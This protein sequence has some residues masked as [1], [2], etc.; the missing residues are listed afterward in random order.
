MSVILYNL[1]LETYAYF[2]NRC[3][4][5]T[6]IDMAMRLHPPWLR[7]NNPTDDSFRLRMLASGRPIILVGRDPVSWLASGYRYTA[8]RDMGQTIFYRSWESH[9]AAAV[10]RNAQHRSH[11]YTKPVN[12]WDN[13]T[14]MPPALQ[15]ARPWEQATHRLRV[16]DCNIVDYITLGSPKWR[17]LLETWF[18]T[19]DPQHFVGDVNASV[20][21][22]PKLTKGVKYLIE[23]LLKDWDTGFYRYNLEHSFEQYQRAYHATQDK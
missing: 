23:H 6:A 21:P 18:D 13:H 15:L 1:R 20:L 16:E 14:W 3:G 2:A 9:L 5:S 10:E 19:D 12:S 4:S 22:M 7:N 11:E 17:N 8:Q